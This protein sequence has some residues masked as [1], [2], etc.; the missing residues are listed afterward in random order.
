[1]IAFPVLS[2]IILGHLCIDL[3]IIC[4]GPLSS[5]NFD[6]NFSY[7]AFTASIPRGGSNPSC[8]YAS[9]VLSLN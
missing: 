7:L 6:L 8:P 9:N 1:L 3:I 2:N 4:N 5:L